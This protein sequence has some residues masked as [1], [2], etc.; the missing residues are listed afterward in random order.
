MTNLRRLNAALR[1]Q[2]A[3]ALQA[4]LDAAIIVAAID[5][6][7]VLEGAVIDGP[8]AMQNALSALALAIVRSGR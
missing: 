6:N 8:V 5:V 1:D 4:K 2:S 7:R 3:E